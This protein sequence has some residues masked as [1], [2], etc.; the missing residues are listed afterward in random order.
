MNGSA[1]ED[2]WYGLAEAVLLLTGTG[3]LPAAEPFV[4]G[5]SGS[6]VQDGVQKNSLVCRAAALTRTLEPSVHC[7]TNTFAGEYK[8]FL[9]CV[10]IARKRASFSSFPLSNAPNRTAGTTSEAKRRKK[11]NDKLKL[12]CTAS[13]GGRIEK[14][15]K[16]NEGPCSDCF[17]ALREVRT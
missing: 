13:E 12:L 2:K 10:L 16:R 4:A 1:E 15:K 7:E 3:A 6:I 17:S 14:R 11:K 9:L 5:A 8:P